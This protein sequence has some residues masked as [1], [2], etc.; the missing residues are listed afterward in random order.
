MTE[1]SHL[2]VDVSSSAATNPSLQ[3]LVL[4]CYLPPALCDLLKADVGACWHQADTYTKKQADR[5]AVKH[6]VTGKPVFEQPKSTFSSEV[7][8]VI[9]QLSFNWH[10][11]AWQHPS[12]LPKSLQVLCIPDVCRDVVAQWVH[13][14]GL[15]WGTLTLLQQ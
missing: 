12:E 9:T 4:S 11:A 15:I 13:D 1:L 7:T 2:H 5:G 8:A 3:S 10:C 14:D 6:N